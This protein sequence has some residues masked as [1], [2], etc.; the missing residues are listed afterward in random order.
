MRDSARAIRVGA[1]V[2]AIT[3]A[4]LMGGQAMA[5]SNAAGTA[6]QDIQTD[7]PLPETQEA[8]SEGDTAD[9]DAIV[10]TGSNIAGVKQVGSQAVT[11]GREEILASGKNSVAD[12]LRTLPQVQN[13]S[14]SF[15]SS[16]NGASGN[17]QTGGNTTRGTAINLRGVGQGGTLTLVDGHR[18][19][20]SGTASAFTEANQVPIAAV[21]RIEVILD[22]ASA[23][24]GSDAIAG[25]INYVL[26]KNFNGVELSGRYTSAENGNDEYALS[27]VGGLSWTAGMGAGNI[28]ATFEYSHRDPFRRYNN[29]RLR[30]DQREYGGNDNRLTTGGTAT[31]PLN[32]NIVVPTVDPTNPFGAAPVN[33]AFTLGGTNTY[34]ALPLNPT[35]RILGV[36]DLQEVRSGSC[37]GAATATCASYPN[38][39]D[40]ALYEDYLSRQTRKQAAIILNQDVG[41]ISFYDE[42]FWGRTDQFTRTYNGS[43]GVSNPTLTIDPTSQY[44]APLASLPNLFRFSTTNF[45]YGYQ[46]ITVQYNL[47]SRLPGV[48]IGN[49]NFDETFNNTFGA[50]ANLFGDVKGE[51]YYNFGQNHTCGV[52]YLGNFVSF[53][54]NDLAGLAATSAIQ[55]LVNLPSSNAL[56]L[57]PLSTAPLTQAQLDYVLGS[58]KQYSQ[59]WSH[60]V[61][62]KID[63]TL[64]DWAPGRWKFAVGG[65]Y[66]SGIQKLQNGANRPPDQG[67]VTTWDANARTTRKQYAAFGELYMPLINAEMGIP[68]V[69]DFTVS[70]AARY[71][72][73]S[74]FG[75]TKNSKVSA[76]WELVE[77]L[78]L[79]GSWGTSFR[80]P[81][82]PELNSGAF[83]FALGGNIAADPA[84]NAALG[85]TRQPNGSINVINIIGGNPNLKAETGTNW[86]FGADFTPSFAPGL[87]LSGTYYNLSYANKLGTAGVPFTINAFVP[88]ALANLTQLNRY[89]AYV[90]PLNNVRTASGCT[91]IDPKAQQYS[92][93]LYT[94]IAGFNPRDLCAAD[95]I[96]DGRS[97]SAAKTLQEG[98]DASVNYTR[99]TDIGT[100][101]A[102][103]SVSHILKNA[104]AT[105]AGSPLVS[106]LDTVGDPISWRG[107]SSLTYNR[108][109]FTTSLFGNYVGSY[110]NDLPI[111]LSGASA[112]LPQSRV[113][114]WTT[115]DLNLTFAY[116]R[117]EERWSFMRGVRLSFA[118]TNVF[119]SE[120]PIV[121]ST[122]NGNSSID[123]YAHNA[124]GRSMQFSLTKAF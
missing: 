122:A 25:V 118:V 87:R 64:I 96:I 32:G 51:I 28:I 53:E 115:F 19:T 102:N 40:R 20:P 6:A 24:Y 79:R 86:Q 89:S 26:R 77:G 110:T 76:T 44:Y 18:I 3:I 66:Y 124:Y 84:V 120:P 98:V 106:R 70:T 8:P 71:D 99:M 65:E 15:D 55:Q 69:R 59:N 23:V 33:S 72:H 112:P 94:A 85:G 12:V 36:A 73:Y 42:F 101:S 60:D 63:G 108:G 54:A 1:S 47:A 37:A 116:P 43:N 30:E 83:S 78:K 82:L 14:G 9:N 13:V 49:E 104:E 41:P 27:G 16:S 50:R 39:V 35:G 38:V 7:A 61:V 121:L 45:T 114:S 34:Y 100:F 62:A 97:I 109:A 92:G 95:L 22:G 119:G 80:A 90:I 91:S 93:F 57:N 58:N 123:L 74:D 5:Q 67:S 2:A 105:V 11:V 48:A 107:R 113:P 56:A 75:D 117:G 4:L 46:P 10:V 29:A 52:C 81:G 111:T 17:A 88:G 31:V 21:E 103:V 68:L